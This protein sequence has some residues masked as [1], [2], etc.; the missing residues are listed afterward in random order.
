MYMHGI[1]EDP[2]LALV[3]PGFPAQA[4]NNAAVQYKQAV[5]ELSCSFGE[6][7]GEIIGFNPVHC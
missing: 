6:K 4:I 2:L 1:S 7:N 3:V 5:S